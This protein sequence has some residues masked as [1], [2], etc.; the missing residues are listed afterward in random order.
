MRKALLWML[1]VTSTCFSLSTHKHLHEK[2]VTDKDSDRIIK[3]IAMISPELISPQTTNKTMAEIAN[4]LMAS[5]LNTPVIEKVLKTLKCAN[6]YNVIH[7]N[8]LT[9]IDYSLPSSEKR[10]WVFDLYEKKLLFHTYVSHGIKS[11]TLLSTSFSNKYNSK[12]SSIGVYK[13]EDTY[14]GRDGLSLKLDGLDAGFN[15]N[16]SNRSVVMHG[17]WYVSEDFIKK[18]GRA[19]RSW[20][21]PA[22]PLAL[23]SAIINTIKGDSLFVIYYPSDK[24]FL[25]S[26]FLNCDN[27][28][29]TRYAAVV[30]TEIKSAEQE[31]REPVL[32]AN[33]NSK[34]LGTEPILVMAAVDYERVFHTKAPLGR[35]L[36]RQINNM[37]YIALSNTEL[38]NLIINNNKEAL[39]TVYFVIPVVKMVRGYYATEMHIVDLGKIK[40]VRLNIEPSQNLASVK[41]YTVDFEAKPS[42]RLRATNEFIRWL[43]L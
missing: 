13:T 31:Q 43:G 17:G 20:G 33:I 2:A 38:E 12:S 28:S 23:T 18:Y 15:D 8:I 7:N 6:E 40:E 21:C 26:K 3:I 19:G 41:S 37:E 10:L 39:N 24:W 5:T 32:F 36:R 29:P 25:K 22:L 1:A 9:I 16:A 11:G 14:Y 30:D 42:I 4:M 35:M 34:N 27:L